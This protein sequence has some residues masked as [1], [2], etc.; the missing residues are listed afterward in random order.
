MALAILINGSDQVIIHNNNVIVMDIENLLTGWPTY[1]I[2]FTPE[3]PGP[4]KL[5][6]HLKE[7]V[8]MVHIEES[9]D[10][11]AELLISGKPKWKRTSLSDC[12]SKEIKWFS[13]DTVKITEDLAGLTLTS[14]SSGNNSVKAKPVRLVGIPK[15]PPPYKPKF[16]SKIAWPPCRRHHCRDIQDKDSIASLEM[17]RALPAPVAADLA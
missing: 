8:K 17:L 7:P 11:E 3:N 4:L 10:S 1:E 12:E 9:T 6:I 2:E 16:D 13:A 14:Q 5:I 15:N